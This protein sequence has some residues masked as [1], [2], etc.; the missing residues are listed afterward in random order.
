MCLSILREIKWLTTIICHSCSNKT[1]SEW[2]KSEMTLINNTYS[3]AWEKLVKI[4]TVHHPWMRREECPSLIEM[5]TDHAWYHFFFF[6]DTMNNLISHCF[7][8]QHDVTWVVDPLVSF[9]WPELI[10]LYL[11]TSSFHLQQDCVSMLCLTSFITESPLPEMLIWCGHWVKVCFA[12]SYPLL[13]ISYYKFIL[14]HINLI[15]ETGIPLVIH[16][17]EVTC[18]DSNGNMLCYLGGWGFL[19]L[20]PFI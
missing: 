3:G 6:N 9:W 12:F 17:L 4:T 5:A 10:R 1:W 8:H 14:S 20:I 16:R 15:S 13:F 2:L 7:N 19:C 11:V 18:Y